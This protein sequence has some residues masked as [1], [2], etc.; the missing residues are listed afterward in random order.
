METRRHEIE[1]TANRLLRKYDWNL[2]E[3]ENGYLLT[4]TDG[5]FEASELVES[6]EDVEREVESLLKQVD[7]HRYTVI[8]KRQ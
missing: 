5:Q 6:S 7:D 3:Q 1:A 8:G 4:V 2:K